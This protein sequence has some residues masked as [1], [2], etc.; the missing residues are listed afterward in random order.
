M[1]RPLGLPNFTQETIVSHGENTGELRCRCG[2][3]CKKSEV[4]K[5]VDGLGLERPPKDRVG[6]KQKNRYL[7]S[8]LNPSETR[9]QMWQMMVYIEGFCT[10]KVTWR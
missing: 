10:E 9:M 7:G 6:I 5:L 8:N 3:S 4:Q 1:N 2:K